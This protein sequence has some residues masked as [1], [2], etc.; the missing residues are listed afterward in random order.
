MRRA[1][2]TIPDDLEAELSAYFKTQDV[3]PSLT[4]L[5]ETALRRFLE[6][7]RFESLQYQ[8]PRKSFRPTP[9]EKGSGLHDV[10]VEHDRYLAEPE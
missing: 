6:E 2:I 9:A 4:G 8:S 10:S 5:V 7:K 3:A 1:T